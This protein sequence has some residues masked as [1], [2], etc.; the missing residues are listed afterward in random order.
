MHV[1]TGERTMNDTNPSAFGSLI[2]IFY[3]PGKTLESLRGKAGRLWMPFLVVAATNAL[4]QLWYAQRVD[5]AW[6]ADQSLASQAANMTADQLRDAHARFTPGS[7]IFFGTVFGTVGLVLWYLAQ[8]LYFFLAAKIGGY[9]EQ[10][11]GSWLSFICWTSMPALVG[12]IATAAYM[13]STS[14]RQISPVD[15]DITSLNTLLFHV[16]Y[17]H[18]GQFIASSF[19]ITTIWSWAIMVI[20]FSRWTGKPLSRSAMVVL[21]PYTVLYAVFILWAMR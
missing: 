13:L 21:A 12:I 18:D 6:F 20:G 15:I 5:I 1:D 11:F 19:R 2:N 16:P 9:K 7:M 14:S 3:E 4:L 8:G 17:A 10:G